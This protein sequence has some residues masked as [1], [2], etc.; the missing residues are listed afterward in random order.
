MSLVDADDK[1]Q[2]LQLLLRAYGDYFD[3]E[4]DIV[5]EGVNF[6]AFARF[7]SRSEKFVLTKAAKLWAFEMNEYVFFST[8]NSLD[9]ETVLKLFTAARDNGF[10]RIRPHKEH[11]C[12]NLTLVII[13]DHIDPEAAKAIK[14]TK[15]RKDFLLSIHGW[16]EFR[17]AAIDL[18]AGKIFANGAAKDVRK[19]LEQ[20][21]LTK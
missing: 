18:S 16:T 7:F 6:D 3:V 10:S 5:A 8:V 9:S 17:I 12:T 20:N 1:S 21:L 2:K 14:K 13:A 15:F 4:R 11:M 19:T